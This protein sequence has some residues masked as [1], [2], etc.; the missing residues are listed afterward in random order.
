MMMT[1]TI[2]FDARGE[3]LRRLGPL[4]GGLALV[5]LFVALFLLAGPEE[6]LAWTLPLAGAVAAGWLLRHGFSCL[7][8]RLRPKDGA[9]PS[10]GRHRVR[11]CH[12]GERCAI[13]AEDA[14][15]AMKIRPDEM[16]LRRLALRYGDCGFFQ[17]ENGR[18]WFCEQALLDWLQ[19]RAHDGDLRAQH[20]R[21][22]LEREALPPEH[23]Q[24]RRSCTGQDACKHAD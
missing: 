14:L 11:L 7:A 13:D 18:W 17:D 22:W 6:A 12:A 1:R 20:F 15:R 4:L 21:H 23:L 9:G 5:G 2:S 16:T 19:R 3:R 10:F 24:L 8:G